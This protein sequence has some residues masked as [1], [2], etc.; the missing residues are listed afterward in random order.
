MLYVGI[1]LFGFSVLFTIAA[2][3]VELNASKSALETI[4]NGNL[5]YDDEYTGAKRTLRAAAMTYDAAALTAVLQ[6]LRLL[7][8]ANNRRR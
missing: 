8:I 5:L 6:L 4:R 7:V 1:G 3:P 2:R